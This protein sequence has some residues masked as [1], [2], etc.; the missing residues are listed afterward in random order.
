M[1]TIP[2]SFY[3]NKFLLYIVFSIRWAS[4]WSTF[5]A[6]RKSDEYSMLV[7]IVKPT[8][9]VERCT[10]FLKCIFRF[11]FQEKPEIPGN[12]VIFTVLLFKI[13]LYLLYIYYPDLNFVHISRFRYHDSRITNHKQLF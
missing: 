8:D 9:S 7:A 2:C 4:T 12:H 13:F 10:G 11:Q 5:R 6:C 1:S 3:A